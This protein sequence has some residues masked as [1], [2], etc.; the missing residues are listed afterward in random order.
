MAPPYWNLPIICWTPCMAWPRSCQHVTSTIP[1]SGKMSF[2]EKGRRTRA[3]WRIYLTCNNRKALWSFYGEQ[4]VCACLTSI[5]LRG[6]LCFL[7]QF[8]YGKD[9]ASLDGCLANS[10]NNYNRIKYNFF[11]T[12]VYCWCQHEHTASHD[13]TFTYRDCYTYLEKI[14]FYRIIQYRHTNACF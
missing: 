12:K 1:A 8:E 10:N 13:K 11:A 6:L 14:F 5:P 2:Y 3:E 4:H 7:L 9:L